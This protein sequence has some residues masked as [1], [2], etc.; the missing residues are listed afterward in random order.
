MPVRVKI[1][2]LTTTAD[3]HAAVVAGAD[4]LGLNCYPRSPRFVPPALARELLASVPALVDVVG[5][6]ADCT[7]AEAAATAKELGIATVQLHADQH[8]VADIRPIR[9]V[10]AFRVRDTADLDK[11]TIYL[12]QCRAA[13]LLP[14]AVLLDAH[15]PGLFGGTGQTLPWQLLVGFAPGVPLILAGGLT[16]EN[17]ARAVTV[18]RPF[19]VDVASGVESGPARKDSERM[20][21]FVAAAKTVSLASD[22]P[23]T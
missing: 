10:P 7:W 19:A 15:A 22:F 5:V 9:C 13:N 8:T 11:I 20:R 4:A 17:V 14:A 2:G 3:I 6:F 21:A 16:P 12:D 23:S 18:V 1:C